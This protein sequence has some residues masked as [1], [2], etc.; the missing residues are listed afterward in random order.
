MTTSL[1]MERKMA[2]NKDIYTDISDVRT[3]DLFR[4]GVLTNTKNT[5]SFKE[6]SLEREKKDI[7]PK[8]NN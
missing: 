1:N 6:H 2:N 3:R 4:L 7:I 8:I 5:P